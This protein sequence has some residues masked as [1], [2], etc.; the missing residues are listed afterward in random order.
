MTSNTAKKLYSR[1]NDEIRF[2]LG[3]LDSTLNGHSQKARADSGNWSYA[4][5]LGRTRDQLIDLIGDLSGRGRK[6]IE[7][8]LTSCP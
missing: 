3:Y 8:S 2:L 1:N 7:E 6:A 4:A 5:D